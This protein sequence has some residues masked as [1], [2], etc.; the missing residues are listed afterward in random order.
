MLQN[1][2]IQT[3]KKTG[4]T[5]IK[6][7]CRICEKGASTIFDP[8]CMKNILDLLQHEPGTTKLI[9]NHA[10]VKVY[11]EATLEI[12]KELAQFTE[13]LKIYTSFKNT[14]STKPSGKNNLQANTFLQIIE[15]ETNDPY[16]TYVNLVKWK[17]NSQKQHDL[18]EKDDL[19]TIVLEILEK[20]ALRKRFTTTPPTPDIFYKQYI[21][22]YVRPGF[23]DSFLKLNPPADAVFLTSYH[24][25]RDSDKKSITISL[26]TRRTKP[27]KI[28]FLIPP[29]YELSQQEL[30]LLEDVRHHLSSHRP[31]DAGFMDA[32][33]AREYFKRFARTIITSLAEEHKIH[34]SADYIDN[35][36]D[37]F[38]KYTAGFGILEDVLQDPRIQDVY[39]NAPVENNPLHLVVNG[40]EFSSNIYLSN[41][42]VEAL[43][44]R[45]RSLSGRPFSEAIPTLDMDLETYHT[46]VAAI[47]NPLTPKG[48]AFALRRHR[49]HPWTLAHFI[50][51]KM[52]SPF[53]AGLLSLLIDGQSS[54]LIAG[55]RG[56]GKTSLLS[57]L[58]LEIPQRY[59]ILTIEDTSEIPVDT[60]QKLEYKIQSLLTRSLAAG[61]S[62]TEMHPTDTLRTALR[63][64]ESVLILGEV[65]GIEAKVL[66]EAMRVGAAGNLI[67]GTIH[68]STTQAVFERIVHD[69]GVPPTSFKAVDAVIVAAPIRSEGGIE[70]KRRVVQISEILST[71]WT[72]GEHAESVFQDL[73]SYDVELDTLQIADILSIG[74]SEL[75]QKIA[76]KWGIT[77]EKVLENI[78]LRAWM[79]Q[80]IVEA[81]QHNPILLEAETIRDANNAFWMILEE[82]KQQFNTVDYQYIKTHWT[83]WFKQYQ[84]RSL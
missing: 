42:D 12:L 14:L 24:I 51:N 72:Q 36:S 1:C 29:E 79:K 27:E 64:G 19:E 25:S 23:V 20:T 13:E 9:F 61:S 53:A 47:S 82:S 40:E 5:T 10:L 7:N 34:P 6:I 57:A 66:F 41:D 59:R 54:I 3:I 46:R 68:G 39:V 81:A 22:P 16:Q 63:L 32:A 45:F 84:D 80:T 33:N 2:P 73:M 37:I 65:R 43:A 62:S 56:A 18:K 26:Y 67:M 4:E 48:I 44:S 60:L 49:K 74:Q 17:E 28:Y 8:T 55:S 15:K 77:V 38:A 52:L 30:L 71:G 35:L 75:I 21:R 69:I 50:D 70:R 83:N 11:T 31:D 76:K 78:K 58:L